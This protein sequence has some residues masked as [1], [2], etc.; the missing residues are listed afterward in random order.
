VITRRSLLYTFAIGAVVSASSCSI[1]RHLA[2]RDPNSALVTRELA[3]EDAET[4]VLGPPAEVRFVQAPGP[5]K[6]FVTGPRRSVEAFSATRGVLDDGTLRTGEPLKIVVTAPNVTRFV[7]KGRDK[8]VIENFDQAELR[9]ETTGWADVK[10]AG[11]AAVVRLN[12]L[13]TGWADLSQVDAGGAEVALT[14]SRRAIVAPREWAKISGNGD[15]I[16]TTEPRH[17]SQGYGGGRVI[18]AHPRASA[19]TE[20]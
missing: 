7:L 19:N 4:L 6:V 18:R 11:R 10:A 13:G 9:I 2:E 5:G 15:V 3:W 17:V 20:V 12:L 14:G 16:L 8:L 1:S